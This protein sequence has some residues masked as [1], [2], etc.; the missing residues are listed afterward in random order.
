[1]YSLIKSFQENYKDWRIGAHTLVDGWSLMDGPGAITGIVLAYLVFVLRVG[2]DF[3]KNREPLGLK[4]T[5]VAYNGIQVL[6]SMYLVYKIS[7]TEIPILSLF[8]SSCAHTFQSNKF[9]LAFLDGTWWYFMA[10]VSELWDTVFFVLRKKMNQVT[11]LHVYHHASMAFFT[12]CFLKYS[13]TPQAPLIGLI[14]SGVHVIMYFYYMVSALGPSYQKY[15]WWKR[16]IT[17]MQLTQFSIIIAYLGLSM[18]SKC[19]FSR[20]ISYLFIL[21]TSIFFYLFFDF[22]RKSYKKSKN[23]D[24]TKKHDPIEEKVIL[25][26]S[27]ADEE[28][29]SKISNDVA[30]SNEDMQIRNRQ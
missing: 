29:Y 13:P 20:T 19:G 2:P 14:N 8:S 22:Y 17:V 7:F 16:Y 3:M 28:I 18:F 30:M 12:W 11:F 15:I 21:N 4:K 9:K 23:V 26:S 27:N 6:F 10:K 25:K 24:D 5:L 1:M